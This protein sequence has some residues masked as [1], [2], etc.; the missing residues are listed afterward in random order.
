MSVVPLNPNF[1]A[2][3]TGL[4]AYAAACVAY[5]DGLF[6]V[7]DGVSTNKRW[8]P[9]A[10]SFRLMG[11]VAPADFGP[12]ALSAAGAPAAILNGATARYYLLG[13]DPVA[14]KETAPQGGGYVSLINSS[15]ATRDMT[16]PWTPGALAPEFTF[17]RIYRALDGTNAMKLVATVADAAG[18][19]LDVTPDTALLAA[20]AYVA[21][22]RTTLPPVFKGMAVVAKQLW[23]WQAGSSRAFVAQPVNIGSLFVGDDFK[24][25]QFVT[26]GPGDGRGDITALRERYGS[27][28]WY[29]Q[30]AR[31]EMTGTDLS[32][33]EFLKL[34][35]DRGAI[36][37]RC[38]LDVNART[39][40]LDERGLYWDDTSAQSS[41][42][43]GSPEDVAARQ[44]SPSPLQP[45]WDRMNLGAA[46]WFFALLDPTQRLAFFF[47]ALDYEP[48]PNV[49][50]V[51]DYD[52]NR[53]VGV[54][55][56]VWG[57]AG[58]TLFDA[59]GR[60]HLVFGC[61][62]GFLR[63]PGYSNSQ[64]VFAGTL[65]SPV[66]ASSATGVVAAAA[67]WDTG[68]LT[69]PVGEPLHRRVTASLA[70]VDANRAY[71][72]SATTLTTYYYPT[73]SGGSS[74]TVAVGVIAGL[75]L[76]P[77]M[78]L[79]ADGE[80]FDVKSCEVRMDGSS[81]GTLA[82]WTA[83]NEEALAVK[84][85][86]DLSGSAVHAYVPY[87]SG[88]WTYTIQFTMTDASSDFSIRG[89]AI[90]YQEFKG[91]QVP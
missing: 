10:A 31:Y 21:T 18:T 70:V 72:V 9:A 61:D 20:A 88:C 25:D 32:T 76:F 28:T 73:A 87:D 89:M 48:V 6:F 15:G 60:V 67:A 90:H 29:K 63:E 91:R 26:V 42:A 65:S 85:T 54:D 62:L 51:Y 12:L 83:A 14:V 3:P 41:Y 34:N 58:G 33:W 38:M 24:S 80:N 47:V 82:V 56:L 23:G 2:G 7:C 43:G 22:Y 45:L 44:G 30:R 37:P 77:K 36:N 35:G 74:E 5:L 84:R 68:D 86:I 57:T 55:T 19:Y 16:I 79:A 4:S 81:G 52:A 8:D 75:A 53:Y 49:A 40:I 64:G 59:L 39:L 1:I 46:D 13:Y 78:R 66:T 69:G 27:A 17:R 11:S 71:S 50:V